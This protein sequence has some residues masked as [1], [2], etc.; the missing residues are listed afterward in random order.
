MVMILE[1]HEPCY[2]TYV[3]NSNVGGTGTQRR[4]QWKLSF[5]VLDKH[6]AAYLIHQIPLS[7]LF[8]ANDW[9]PPDIPVQHVVQ[10]VY[11]LVKYSWYYSVYHI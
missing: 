9:F 11:L 8:R 1:C 7:Y 4:W 6:L 3:T 10:S 2:M 5:G